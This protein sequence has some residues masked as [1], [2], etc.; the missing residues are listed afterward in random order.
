MLVL[1]GINPSLA[2]A[3]VLTALYRPVERALLC[4]WGAAEMYM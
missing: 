2:I 3:M 1:I 4:W